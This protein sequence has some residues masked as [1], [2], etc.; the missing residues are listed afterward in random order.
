MIL[1]I[2]GAGGKTTL[3]HDLARRYRAE[4]LRVFATTSTHMRPEA[5]TL[6]SGD[7]DALLA[8]LD[9]TGY[10]MAGLPAGRKLGPLPLPVYEAVSRRADVTLI[11]ADGSKGLPVKFPAAHE[12]VIYDNVDEIAVVC[13]LCGL[14]RPLRDAAH[15]LELVTGC[16]GVEADTPLTAAHVQTLVQKG[17]L[18]PL[19]ARWPGKRIWVRANHDGSP[20]Q[21]AAAALLEAER[22]VSALREEDFPARRLGCV[23]LAAG[24]STRF[25]GQKLLADLNGMPLLART[26]QSIPRAVFAKTVAVVSDDAVQAL[27]QAQG[28]ATVRYDGGPQSESVR[29]GLEAVAD[30]D[31]CLFLPGDQPLCRSFTR[32]TA[33][34][35]ADTP[36]R[37]ADGGVPGS[38][39]L[40]PKSWYPK[41]QT[42]SGDA[43]GAALL[44]GGGALLLEAA[45]GEMLDADTPAALAALRRYI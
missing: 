31:G 45:A 8:A 27:C 13:T 4:G 22:D 2:V 39:V 21:K 40:F 14:H 38:P 43:G 30:T 12:P 20:Y 29:R 10:V 37:L 9:R 19:R 16:L 44:R 17:Y 7:A 25:G 24:Q 42:L 32:L 35:T 3:L 15:R 23:V 28:V 1:A 36:V 5:D 26:L 41:L 34:F 6:L 33:A 11:E 18:E